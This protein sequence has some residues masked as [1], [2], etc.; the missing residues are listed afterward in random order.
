M[1]RR[2]G[3]RVPKNKLASTPAEARAAFEEH[4]G[5]DM[6]IKA[7]A[8]CGGR[9]RGHFSN[10]FKGG[11]HVVTSAAEAETFAAKMLNQ[12]LITK[13]TSS[14]GLPVSKVL[15]MERLYLR[16]ETYF[17]IMMDRASS[18]PLLIGSP[19]GGTSIEEVAAETPDLIFT[20]KVDI[21]EGVRPEQVMRLAKNMGFEGE[22]A[23]EAAQTMTNLYKLFTTSD[24]TLVEIN[25]LA[26]T[27]EGHVYAVV[28]FL[29]LFCSSL[30]LFLFLSR[31][32][33][34]AILWRELTSQWAI[35]N[36]SICVGR[37]IKL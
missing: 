30:S 24:S 7:Q 5:T 28:C 37:Q 4:K 27:P 12:R 33:K 10:G 15:L 32:N 8:L 6:V 11:V 14:E 21:A 31:K 22:A 16:R 19:R 3:V 9:G 36:A 1:R 29:H 25:P 35:K 18:G 34:E 20:E 23:T 2:T 13:Q 17:S 26:E